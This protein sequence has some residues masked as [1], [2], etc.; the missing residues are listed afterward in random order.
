MSACARAQNNERSFEIA[1]EYLMDDDFR[2][3]FITNLEKA[4]VLYEAIVPDPWV[5]P[6]LSDYVWFHKVHAIYNVLI[7]TLDRIP[8]G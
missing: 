5:E 7:R 3:K 2:Q 4:D 8:K 1:T 6:F